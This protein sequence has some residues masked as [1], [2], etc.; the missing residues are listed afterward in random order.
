MQ[1]KE[2]ASLN[3][4]LGRSQAK[5]ED[6]ELQVKSTNQA[7]KVR[8]PNTLG[9]L[10]P[11]W[12]PCS[13]NPMTG[14]LGQ[15][16]QT[17]LASPC[18]NI[19]GQ[20]QPLLASLPTPPDRSSHSSPPTPPDRSSHSSPISSHRCQHRR[21][22]SSDDDDDGDYGRPYADLESGRRTKSR[23]WASKPLV[24]GDD[25]FGEEL[26]DLNEWRFGEE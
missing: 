19:A 21:Y 23:C 18:R 22:T 26:E 17:D 8:G 3:K 24:S 6:L 25:V 16:R 12:E 14:D 10:L 4:A 9:T 7:V 11:R 1:Q 13:H 2:V 20:I 5:L 15:R